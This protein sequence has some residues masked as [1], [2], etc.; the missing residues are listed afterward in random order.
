M[1]AVATFLTVPLVI[2]GLATAAL[3][4]QVPTPRRAA[5]FDAAPI[6]LQLP[7]SILPTIPFLLGEVDLTSIGVA[8]SELATVGPT[9]APTAGNQSMLIVDDD[10][11]DCPNAQFTS[12]QAAVAAAAPG[13]MIKV[14][15]GTYVEQ[16][17]IPAGKDNLTLF[18]EGAFQAVLKAP[19]IMIEP[20]A[21]VRINGA[22]DITLRHFTIA[23]PGGGPCDSIRYGVRVDDS[24]SAL[25]TDNHITE[26]HDTPFSGCQ[27]GVGV[28][29]GR[30]FEN[31]TGSGTVV[32]N[33]IDRYQKGGIVVD[34]VIAS[35]PPPDAPDASS[36]SS[37]SNAEVAYNEIDG[38]GAT[39]V[40]AQ[41]G[42]QISRSATANV[43]HNRVSLNNY[44][45]PT[46]SSEAI[47]LF[48]E[49]AGTTVHHNY[50]FLND[51][52]IGLFTTAAADVSHNRSERND[53]D[54][55]F[56]D[57][58]TAS[59]TISYNRLEGNHLFDCQ[60]DSVGPGTAGTANFWIK[61]LGNTENRPGLCKATP[62]R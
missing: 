46:T 23:G 13:D 61:N 48:Q 33:L 18:S 37:R 51:D 47:L 6:P 57:T 25:I 28:L 29:I 40:I 34:G 58:D 52:G 21:I 41:N 2:S 31:T 32:H 1:R 4:G 43:H 24:G 56:A 17:T 7:T 16:V 36:G 38:V 5:P 53:F 55:V 20:K 50:L 30:N 8:D 12:V 22:H 9:A 19:P 62:P 42:I 14:C 15:R 26:I 45:L 27:N 35:E 10:R 49:I 60:D 39:P 44:A 59:N 3:Q 11:A 54:G